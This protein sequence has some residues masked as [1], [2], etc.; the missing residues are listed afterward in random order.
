MKFLKVLFLIICIIGLSTRC[1]KEK[2]PTNTDITS[3]TMDITN[4]CD[5]AILNMQLITTDQFSIIRNEEEYDAN[6]EGTCHPNLDFTQVQ[7]IIGHFY[8]QKIIS[9]FNFKLYL[10][11]EPNY[12]KL[13]ITPEYAI[14][15]LNDE[16][17]AYYY[18]ILVP[19]KEKIEFLKVF[20]IGH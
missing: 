18:Q 19:Q 12:Y 6:I 5:N 11:S 3:S 4:F 16:P 9:R 14:S 1:S 17:V 2:C 13:G 7:L 20:F 10:S 15:G 8:S